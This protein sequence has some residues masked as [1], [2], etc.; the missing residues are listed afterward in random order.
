MCLIF[1]LNVTSL[2]VPV[3]TKNT[4]SNSFKIILSPKIVVTYRAVWATFQPQPSKFLL[5]FPKM[6]RSENIS[7]NSGNRTFLY[8]LKKHIFFYIQEIELSSQMLKKLLIFQERTCKAL[9]SKISYISF[10][11]FGLLRQ[12]FSNISAKA[13]SLLYSP[14]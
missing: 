11:I 4:P 8:L 7:Y 2:I 9:K 3:D 1:I 5:F 12:N 14:S 6:T 13:K 10:H